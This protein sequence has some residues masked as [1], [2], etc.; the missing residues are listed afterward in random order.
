MR[1]V[2]RRLKVDERALRSAIKSGRVDRGVT[3]AGG[4]VTITDAAAAMKAFRD[5]RQDGQD[6]HRLKP[7]TLV[8]A[9]WKLKDVRSR[10]AEFELERKRGKYVLAADVERLWG[11]R[12][13]EARNKLLAVPSRL[14][15]RRP[16][17]TREDLAAV[18]ALI[19]AALTELA[20]DRNQPQ[21]ENTK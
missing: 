8:D 5:N 12:V 21:K 4:R 6:R 7:G 13:I 17:L 18:D 3:V 9:E 11:R 15:G 1:A 14:R 20:D 16:D 10:S 19:R 2:A